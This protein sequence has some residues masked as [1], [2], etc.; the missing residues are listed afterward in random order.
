MCAA[1]E[2]FS[3]D[4]AYEGLASGLPRPRQRAAWAN[5]RKLAQTPLGLRAPPKASSAS[6]SRPQAVVTDACNMCGGSGHRHAQCS[7]HAA[8]KDNQFLSKAEKS[9]DAGCKKCKGKGHWA[10]H[11][12][13]NTQREQIVEPVPSVAAV[14]QN[15][16]NTQGAKTPC[17]GWVTFGVCRRPA[18]T[19]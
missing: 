4:R 18:G 14:T 9:R 16:Q 15:A 13:T 12:N 10:H 5:D 2:L 17:N 3:I 8:K 7:N 19:P 6:G 11:H 1:K